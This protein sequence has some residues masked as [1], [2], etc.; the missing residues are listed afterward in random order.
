M[1]SSRT[2]Q[3]RSYNMMTNLATPFVRS[4]CFEPAYVAP[5]N[6]VNSNE[7]FVSYQSH[8]GITNND[9]RC[10][11]DTSYGNDVVNKINPMRTTNFDARNS[12]WRREYSV[13]VDYA[14]RDFK[15]PD[16]TMCPQQPYYVV[17]ETGTQKVV[18]PILTSNHVQPQCKTC[19]TTVFQCDQFKET[20]PI[21]YQKCR[22]YQRMIHYDVVTPNGQLIPM[23]VEMEGPGFAV[24]RA[25]TQKCGTVCGSCSVN[26]PAMNYNPPSFCHSVI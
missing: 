21:A 4:S 6:D 12:L 9:S 23:A 7:P 3:C 25:A 14:P 26:Y 11:F 22:D 2:G 16:G 20:N 18:C 10:G 8:T 19:L 15:S 24:F 5:I 13:I 1:Y 17:D